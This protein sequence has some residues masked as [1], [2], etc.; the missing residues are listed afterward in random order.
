VLRPVFLIRNAVL[1][2]VL[3]CFVLLAKVC[4]AA[5]MAASAGYDEMRR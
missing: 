5:M 1:C 2:C 3:F 4:T